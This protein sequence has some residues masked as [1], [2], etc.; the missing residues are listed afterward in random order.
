MQPNF[1]ASGY[2]LAIDLDEDIAWLQTCSSRWAVRIDIADECSFSNIQ[3]HSRCQFRRNVLKGNA[4]KAASH[5]TRPD[6]LINDV[7]NHIAWHGETNS[8]IAT[9]RTEY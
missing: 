2:G 3:F 4:H 7:A 1:A 8:Q 9:T 5:F 6:D